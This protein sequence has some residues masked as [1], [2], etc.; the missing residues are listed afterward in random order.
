MP[1]SGR[2]ACEDFPSKRTIKPDEAQ[3]AERNVRRIDPTGTARVLAADAVDVVRDFD[4][5]LRV[6]DDADQ[7]DA[8]A[9]DAQRARLQRRMYRDADRCR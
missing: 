7:P 2:E 5:R 4:G 9:H 8:D 3:R 1:S 6:Y